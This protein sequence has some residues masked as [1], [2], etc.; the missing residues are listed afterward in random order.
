MPNRPNHAED[1]T[2]TE[3]I[4]TFLEWIQCKAAPT[5]LFWQRVGEK[6]QQERRLL[7]SLI[8]QTS[9]EDVI[10]FYLGGVKIDFF[11]A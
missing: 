11:S 2:S 9:S 3:R 6:D 7:I 5:I 4:H 1:Q 10:S 8:G